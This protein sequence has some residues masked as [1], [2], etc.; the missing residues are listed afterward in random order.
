MTITRRDFLKA[1]TATTVG[2]GVSGYGLGL[3]SLARGQDQKADKDYVI[4]L[5]YYNC[6]HMT[7]AP[8]GKDAGIYEELGLKVEVVGNAKVPEAMAAGQMDVG[9]IGFERT[10]RAYLKGCPIF[11]AAMNHLGGSYYLVLRNDLYELYRKD[12][13][14]LL[15]KKLALGTEPEKNQA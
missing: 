4:K 11:I 6:D 8:V 12:P 9:Y 7:A 14:A 10:V 2:L 5:G 13:K 15:G 1:T 3:T